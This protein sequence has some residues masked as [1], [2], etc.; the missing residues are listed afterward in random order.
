MAVSAAT[1][2]L[3]G[4]AL[5]IGT[6]IGVV[7]VGGVLLAP[8]LILFGGL[9][10]HEA[11]ATA[12]C[13][14]VPVGITSAVHYRVALL[15]PRSLE[16]RLVIGLVLG[17]ITGA[18]L[19]GAL[20]AMVLTAVLGGVAGISGLWMLFRPS[21]E[22]PLERESLPTGVGAIFGSV[23]GCGSGLSGTSG[24]VLL[25]PVLIAA[26]VPISKAVAVSQAS[27]AIIAPAGAIAYLSTVNLNYLLTAGL[28][29][30]VAL[31]HLGGRM[32]A[33]LLAGKSQH[34]L[35]AVVLLVTATLMFV[36]PLH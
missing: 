28:S 14:F 5:V 19:N 15:Q 30:T 17:A 21:T 23:I 31:G 2:V 26:R 11:T 7:G 1:V 22:N 6:L 4:A 32:A 34:T 27:Q 20:P 12:L 3:L 36:H 25:V 33:P 16:R 9:E 24:P 13:C 35:A 29:V 8:V 18:L 10:P